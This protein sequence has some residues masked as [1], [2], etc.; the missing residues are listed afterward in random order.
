MPS[1]QDAHP[2][3]SGAKKVRVGFHVAGYLARTLGD[4]ITG[5]KVSE[6]IQKSSDRR[7]GYT[8]IPSD[9]QSTF[10]V[11]GQQ[12]QLPNN[13]M[14]DKLPPGKTLQTLQNEVQDKITRGER[15]LHQIEN[16]TAPQQCSLQNM[17]DVMTY[18]QA[19]AQSQHGNYHEGSMSIPDPGNRIKNFLDTCPDAYQRKSSHIGEFQNQANAMGTH[20]GIDAYGRTRN[21]NEMLP[22][23]MKTVMYGTMEQSQDMKMGE[24]RLW[25]KME[26]HGAWAFSPKVNDPNGPKRSANAH[27]GKAAVGHSLSFLE[28]RGQGS[29]EGSRKERIPDDIKAAWQSLQ[30]DARQD[31]KNTG[32]DP[33]DDLSKMLRKGEGLQTA[34]G[35]RFINSYLEDM[36]NSP[37]LSPEVREKAAYMQHNMQRRFPQDTMDVRIG[38]EVILKDTDLRP[39]NE[40]DI[41]APNQNLQQGQGI[42]ALGNQAANIGRQRANARTL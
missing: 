5:G 16:G 24:Q 3:Y 35:V 17:T 9:G 32:T 33:S 18:L 14:G 4:K 31:L 27:D 2:N 10:D 13:F 30:K 37:E 1:N 39:R 28:T 40:N 29:K 36:K 6:L 7:R 23:N 19:R 12:V 34:R 26:P 15:L 41:P 25:M 8:R 21:P 42:G 20:R 11:G 38:N 22:N